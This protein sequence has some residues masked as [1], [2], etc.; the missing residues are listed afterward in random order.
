MNLLVDAHLPRRLVY[1][2]REA[3]HDVLHTLDLPD[4]NRTSDIEIIA[5]AD[6]EGR[7][8]VTKDADFVTSFLIYQ[9]P[10]R[11]LLL[12]TG[13]IRN[14]ELIALIKANLPAIEA[15]FVTH[16]YVELARTAFIIHS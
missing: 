10:Q 15:A 6:Q 9:R 16:Y 7:I 8:V 1:L 3:G 12:S 14:A 11:L 5:C 2:L 4:G 13:N